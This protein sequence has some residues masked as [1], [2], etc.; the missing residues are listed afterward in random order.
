VGL[1]PRRSW[2]ALGQT[3]SGSD[4]G[5]SRCA[6]AFFFD[7]FAFPGAFEP[8]VALF[9][10]DFFEFAFEV[11]VVF[12]DVQFRVEFPVRGF[13][14]VKARTVFFDRNPVGQLVV[15]F[16]EHLV[17][18]AIG[19]RFELLG[20]PFFA[21]F[22]EFRCFG[23]FF[24]VFEADP[25]F[26]DDHI[27]GA[28]LHLDFGLGAF[29]DVGEFGRPVGVKFHFK[30]LREF[31]GDAFFARRPDQVALRRA[32][33]ELDFRPEG[34]GAFGFDL[35]FRAQAPTFEREGTGPFFPAQV[36][37]VERAFFR[38]SDRG[39]RR[40]DRGAAR[41][42]RVEFA[43]EGFGF[44]FRE[45]RRRERDRHARDRG[46]RDRDLKG[47]HSPKSS[48]SPLGGKA[49]RR[50][51]TN[52][53]A[54]QASPGTPLWPPEIATRHRRAYHECGRTGPAVA[55][56]GPRE[57]SNIWTPARRGPTDVR[58][59]L[60]RRV[61]WMASLALT[62]RPRRPGEKPLRGIS[63]KTLMLAVALLA[64]IA[65]VLVLTLGG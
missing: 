9:H 58:R 13:L 4:A 44:F 53:S 31:D 3:L 65:A 37:R 30:A 21:F 41:D 52:S 39:R 43:E 22:A 63:R 62:N 48:L 18:E 51:P 34:F 8:D 1:S 10:L 20:R 29:D 55:A 14:L 24:E 11:P 5:V 61:G 46:Q 27:A 7:F 56:T 2:R 6:F 17:L 33:L 35:A 47:P 57:K 28:A 25:L 36:H 60:K 23:F 16:D 32:F 54:T 40:R 59:R 42:I 64:V 12:D 38:L 45:R 50:F 19:E 26:G 15:P 49:G